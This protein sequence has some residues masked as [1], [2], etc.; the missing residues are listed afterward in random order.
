MTLLEKIINFTKIQGETPQNYGKLHV[1]FI[2][3]VLF[4]SVALVLLFKDTTDARFRVLIGVMFL[5]MLAGEL[6]KQVFYPLSIVDGQI[7]RDYDWATFPFQLCSTPLY[8]LPFLFLLPDC[9]VRDWTAAYIMSYGLLGGL[10]VYIAPNAVFVRNMFLSCHSMVHHGLQILIGVYTA[11]YYRRRINTS[12]IVGAI[13]IFAVMFAIANVFNTVI[14]DALLAKGV[15]EE[16]ISFNMFY[17]SPRPGQKPMAFADFY[18]SVHPAI[19]IG[20]YFVL[21]SAGAL[22]II[23]GTKLL[24]GFSRKNTKSLT[25]SR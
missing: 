20:G 8:V 12:F 17:I 21:I 10:A 7:I 11:S 6:V 2:V 14:Y 24:F 19:Y 4:A 3:A 16:G 1:W 23:F 25:H 5:I 22:L 13:G 9:K 15:L 18:Y